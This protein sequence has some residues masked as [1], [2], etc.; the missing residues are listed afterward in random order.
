[1]LTLPLGESD[2]KFARRSPVVTMITPKA[3]AHVISSPKTNTPRSVENTI[4]DISIIPYRLTV[5]DLNATKA[6]IQELATINAF[7][8]E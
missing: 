2:F 8:K 1:M 3:F 5:I 4:L 6:S 7:K